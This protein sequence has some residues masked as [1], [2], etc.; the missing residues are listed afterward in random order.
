MKRTILILDK[1]DSVRA[2]LKKLLETEGYR[3][4]QAGNTA[5]ALGRLA[6]EDINLIV[7]DVN[8]GEEDGWKAFERLAAADRFIPTIIVTAE[9]GQF[10]RAMASGV[11]ALIEKPMDVPLF[12]E[13][14]EQL[15]VEDR[16]G[17]LK[18][19]RGGRRSC[20]YVNRGSDALR[21]DLESRWSTPLNMSWFERLHLV[22]CGEVN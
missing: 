12:L 11:E 4:L 14:V 19:A 9:F 1:D 21:R 8:L 2:S 13:L 22:P 20:R 18:R 3:V 16:T 10:D 15:L 6:G 5:E 7:M 17:A